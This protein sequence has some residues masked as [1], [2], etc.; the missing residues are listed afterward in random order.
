[1]KHVDENLLLVP[2]GCQH[3]K[4]MR[5]HS[6]HGWPDERPGAGWQRRCR[7]VPGSTRL[8]KS[9]KCKEAKTTVFGAHHRVFGR[10]VCLA[11]EEKD[12]RHEAHPVPIFSLWRRTT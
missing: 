8:S 7:V 12:V 4:G 3:R 10:A 6:W 2:V 5:G 1:M 11:S 9:V